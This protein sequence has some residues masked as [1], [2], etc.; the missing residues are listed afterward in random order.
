MLVSLTGV[1][2]GFQPCGKVREPMAHRLVFDDR[3]AECAAL[4][5][6]AHG[7]AERSSGVAAEA[8]RNVSGN[9]GYAGFIQATDEGCGRAFDGPLDENQFRHDPVLAVLAGASLSLTTQGWVSGGLRAPGA[10]AWLM[11][12]NGLAT[13]AAF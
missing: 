9:D 1:P 13:A 12:V 8:R 5:G 6:V 7:D 2:R 10:D 3:L 4:L 11:A